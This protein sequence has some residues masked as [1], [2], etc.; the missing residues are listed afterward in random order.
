MHTTS[1]DG[2][3]P[4]A[5]K[6]ARLRLIRTETVGPTTF[7]ALIARYGS[8]VA[9]LEAIPDL[10]ARG[11][12]RR[13]LRIPPKAAAEREMEAIAGFGAEALFLGDPA[14][15]GL[16]AAI[17]DAPPV[18][19]AK[20]A[21]HLLA[22]PTLAIVGARNASSAGR[23]LSGDIARA[24]GGAGVTV[25][26]G[27]ARGIDTAAH[28]ASLDTGTIAAVAGGLDVIYPRENAELQTAIAERG[29]LV[30]DEPLGVQPQARH[31]PKRN[32]IISG[33]ALGVL[34]V[35][36]AQRSG[37]LITARLAAE[38][39]REVFAVP[40]SPLDPRA[41]GTNVLI[42]QGATLVESAID[43]L[44]VLGSLR[45]PVAEPAM[46]LFRHAAGEMPMDDRL[47]EDI[48]RQLRELLSPAPVAIDDLARDCDAPPG[49]I[50]VA[51]LELELAGQAE[52][53][54]GGRISLA[55]DAA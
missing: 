48:R 9:A 21:G 3:L 33:L 29:L 45:P 46:D 4:V 39:G 26:S 47:T 24:V 34:V 49:A 41:K 54:P 50:L 31:F 43:V 10:A 5:E 55:A 12:R 40:G 22:R 38:Q 42:R 20:G 28:V 13:P 36:A 19:L 11:G 53:H 25:I 6:L 1:D 7:R 8:A 52:R 51:I 35:E 17:E 16:L 27:L 23:R 44:D 2:P 14:Y 15:P 30:S 32:R 18:L 37:S